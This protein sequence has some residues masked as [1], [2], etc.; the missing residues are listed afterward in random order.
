M[1]QFKKDYIANRISDMTIEDEDFCCIICADPLYAPVECK[2]CEALICGKC[3]DKL[4]SG[5]KCPM[6]KTTYATR[7]C[8][9]NSMKFLNQTHIH[10]DKCDKSGTYEEILNHLDT[11]TTQ[12]YH[13]PFCV[14]SFDDCEKAKEH[15]KNCT[16]RY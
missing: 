8:N 5:K 1:D 15:I 9:K 12:D 14:S 16:H 13:C 10:C 7:G 2:T 6:C 11:C 3:Y 4:N